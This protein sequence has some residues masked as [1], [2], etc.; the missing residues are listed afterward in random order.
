MEKLNLNKWSTTLDTTFDGRT[1]AQIKVDDY[2]AMEGNLTGYDCPICRNKGKIMWLRKDQSVATYDCRCKTIRRNLGKLDR[3]GLSE[4][5]KT[6][7]FDSFQATEGWQRAL[8]EGVME[9]ARSEGGWLLLSGSSGCGKTHLCTA[10]CAERI[11]RYTDMQYIRW[12]EESRHLKTM[13][14]GDPGLEQR[15]QE[16]KETPFLY[17]DDL[18]KTAR[19]A[20]GRSN[21]TQAEV[22]LAFEIL[23]YRYTCHLSTILSTE[24]SFTELMN[25][26]SAIA[27]RIRERCG[28]HIYN[29]GNHPER[30]YRLRIQKQT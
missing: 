8:K 30:N 24:K 20:D 1:L 11:D 3:A 27:S 2:N 22:K 26:D 16:L 28:Q 15:L 5:V 21:P 23:D 17:I 12:I 14:Y 9:Y 4:S 29:L 6:Q 10:V 13:N 19:G 18:F 7:T 25:I